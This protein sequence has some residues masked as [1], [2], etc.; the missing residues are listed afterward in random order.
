[1]LNKRCSISSEVGI[2]FTVV[3]GLDNT[4]DRNTDPE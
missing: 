4:D 1:M 3:S 2:T